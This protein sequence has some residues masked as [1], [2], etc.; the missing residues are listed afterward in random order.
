MRGI[1]ET[2]RRDTTRYSQSQSGFLVQAVKNLYSHPA[3]A[4]VVFYRLGRW[5][6]S[7][8][9]N[10]V[11]SVLYIV[12]RLLYPLVRWYSGVELQARTQIGAGLC[13]MHFGPVVIHPSVIAGEDLT[14]LQGVT[15]GESR[16]GAPILG[17]RVAIGVGATVI[18]RV[19][20]GDDVNIG[21]GAVV[22]RDLPS[23]CTA[24][25]VPAKP[26]ARQ[27]SQR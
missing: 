12:Y 19:T 5:A 27:H 10:P 17:N 16:E 14:V 7:G 20:I 15:I 3:F 22:V 21:A 24:V 6:W 8:R 9:R 23:G 1:F 11:L 13:V 2:L 25:G 26:L 18:G 4:A